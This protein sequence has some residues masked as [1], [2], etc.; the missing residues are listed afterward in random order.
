MTPKNGTDTI[1]AV[2]QNDIGYIKKDVL[3]IKNKLEGEYVTKV[4]FAP[5]QKLVYGLVSV[6]LIGV[7]TG[8]LALVLK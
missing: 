3:E 1:L 8:L 5:L 2:I 6:V 4:E 7:V